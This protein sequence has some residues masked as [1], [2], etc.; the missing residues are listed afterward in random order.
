MSD[1]HE[2][3]EY[4][5]KEDQ[6][7]RGYG[8]GLMIFGAVLFMIGGFFVLFRI[9]D[10]GGKAGEAFTIFAWVIGAPG[11][12]IGSLMFISGFRRGR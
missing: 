10:G 5:D 9:I 2:N 4:E 11:L 1:N 7:K 3:D 12:L 8:Y 6:P